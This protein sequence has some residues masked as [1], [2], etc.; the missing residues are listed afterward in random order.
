MTDSSIIYGL[1]FIGALVYYLQKGHNDPMVVFLN[2]LKA[3]VWPAMV[4]Y[5]LM[6]LLKL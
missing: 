1:A 2:I 5:K 4:V 3:I 6:G